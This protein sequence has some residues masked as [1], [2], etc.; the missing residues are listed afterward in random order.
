M[1]DVVIHSGAHHISWG[2]ACN[3]Q[4]SRYNGYMVS[5]INGYERLVH[6]TGTKL[7][8]YWGEP[9]DEQGQVCSI[10]S[11]GSGGCY[12][13]TVYEDSMAVAGWYEAYPSSLCCWTDFLR[14]FVDSQWWAGNK[15][16]PHNMPTTGDRGWR[17]PNSLGIYG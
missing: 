4:Y 14:I 13:L 10:E 11:V 17:N 8:L 7:T 5:K 3:C 12:R 6:N 9:D 2:W 15:L 16:D 1:S